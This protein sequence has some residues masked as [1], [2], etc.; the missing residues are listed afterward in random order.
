MVGR[1]TLFR[2]SASEQRL[3][4]RKRRVF[5]TKCRLSRT[6][7]TV[8]PSVNFKDT[9][10]GIFFYG[11]TPLG[12]SSTKTCHSLH[13]V[14]V[15]FGFRLLRHSAALQPTEIPLLGI[16]FRF[17]PSLRLQFATQ[18]FTSPDLHLFGLV[19]SAQLRPTQIPLNHLLFYILKFCIS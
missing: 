14:V 16:C 3:Q 13:F 11:R 5:D 6:S 7:K 12:I 4:W 9:S 10:K 2:F 15:H 18:I 8:R 17:N 19:R 1:R